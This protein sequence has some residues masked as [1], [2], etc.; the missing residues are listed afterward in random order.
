MTSQAP[1]QARTLTIALAGQPNVGKT[2]VFNM[3]TGLNQHVGNWPGKTVEQKTGVFEYKGYTIHLVDLPGTYSLTANSEEERIARDYILRE[4]PDAVIVMLNAASLERTLYLLA[5]L[6]M[7][8]SPLVVGLNMVDV[9]RQND[10]VVEEHVLAAALGLPVIPVVASHN[11]G[12]EALLDAAI[13][14]ALHPEGGQSISR[15]QLKPEHQAI[16]ERAA[17]LLRGRLPEHYPPEWAALKVL[18][19]DSEITALVQREAPDA[20]ETI[21]AWL[22]EHED[23]YLDIAGGRYAW[24]ERLVRAAMRQPR[25]GSI[26]LT[27]RVDRIATHPFWGL[28]VLLGV[29]GAI[30]WVTYTLAL[31]VVNWLADGV[32]TPLASWSSRSLSFA[33]P[34][35][36]GLV[37][38]GLIGGVGMVLSFIPILVTFFA[39]LG[40]LEDVGYLARAAYVMDRFMHWMGLHGRSFLP[41][42][43]GFGC[44]VPGVMGTRI[45]EDRRARLLTILLI[46]L[47]PCTARM[48]VITFLAPAF[49]G[50]S[51]P[52]VVWGLVA[53]NLLILAVLGVVV[54]KIAFQGTRTAFI[55]EIP[56]YHMPNPR[57]IALFVW[58]K[59]KAFVEGAG[60]VILITAVVVWWLSYWPDGN[61]AHSLLARIGT[62][63]APVGHLLG[64]GDWRMT[65]ALLSSFLAKENTI[66]TLGVLYGIEAGHSLSATIAATLSRPGAL[67]FLTVQMLFIPCAAT[68][69]AI[70]QEAGGKWAAA[71]VGLL[72][73]ISL[74]AGAAVFWIFT[75]IGW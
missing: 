34:W 23:T 48:S 26:T 36:G 75:W 38:D 61:I 46:P 43:L 17:A 42:F 18:E 64:W 32:I 67:A 66:A 9:A 56:I 70:K 16:L 68:I 10:M 25:A 52:L 28:V 30:F 2:T 33:P 3:L 57:T 54:N 73:A 22:M 65:V 27:D 60:E 74:L 1:A 6:V 19:G 4:Q 31:P 5:E 55:M 40:F 12:L 51:A 45:I 14:T 63:V 15:P 44:N 21:E 35:V 7:L 41:L 62:W 29:F 20:W 69:A 13:E 24:I 71:S 59:T 37:S 50:G 47:V 39:V 49:F 72:L 53:I 8:P 11:Q 58:N